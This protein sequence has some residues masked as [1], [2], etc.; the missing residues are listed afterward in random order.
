[1]DKLDQTMDL[2][3]LVSSFQ[4][5]LNWTFVERLWVFPFYILQATIYLWLKSVQ[6]W[7]LRSHHQF[8]SA[9]NKATDL[10]DSPQSLNSAAFWSSLL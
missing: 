10:P 7:S 6:I 9:S 2:F 8:S 1:M 5:I 3:I 4:S